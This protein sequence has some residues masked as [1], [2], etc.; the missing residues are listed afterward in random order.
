MTGGRSDVSIQDFLLGYIVGV[1]SD[2]V[3]ETDDIDRRLA[4]LR[5]EVMRHG[6][7]TMNVASGGAMVTITRC[8]SCPRDDGWPCTTLRT[9]AA[10]YSRH[11]AYQPEWRPVEADDLVSAED[12]PLRR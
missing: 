3:H 5:T 7:R 4:R 1:G 2:E 12:G 11:P 8:R 6:P 10:P 9:L